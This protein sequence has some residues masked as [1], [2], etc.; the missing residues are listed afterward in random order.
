MVGWN[1]MIVD[2]LLK[3]LKEWKEDEHNGHH[4]YLC[5]GTNVKS[6]QCRDV[7]SNTT[8]K[9]LST[10]A[11]PSGLLME[12]GLQE[13]PFIMMLLE[14]TANTGQNSHQMVCCGLDEIANVNKGVSAQELQKF[15]PD[16]PV[17]G[18]TRPREINLLI[19][20]REGKLVSQRLS[21]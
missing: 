8:S 21:Y 3:F 4:Y 18:L 1:L 14:V 10:V 13:H 11:R 20:H 17:D 7:F 16:I 12:S 9:T 19:S 15:F 6:R 5:P 2:S